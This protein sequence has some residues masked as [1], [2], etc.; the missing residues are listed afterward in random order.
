[1]FVVVSPFTPTT[2]EAISAE[3]DTIFDRIEAGEIPEAV[4]ELVELSATKEG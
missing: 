1:M 2:V 4:G 3:L